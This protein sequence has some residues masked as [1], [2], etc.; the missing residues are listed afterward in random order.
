[1]TTNGGI[2]SSCYGWPSFSSAKVGSWLAEGLLASLF[3]PHCLLC[4]SATAGLDILCQGCL[5]SLPQ[6]TGAR[7]HRCQ[8]PLADPGADLCRTCG[9]QNR[10][11]DLARA[12]GPYEGSWGRLVCALKYGREKAVARFL[13]SRLAQYVEHE[14]AF[15]KVD[16]ITF[17]PMTRTELKTRGFNQ[18]LLLAHQFAKLVG[19]PVRRLMEKGR[20]TQPQV[21][22]SAKERRRNLH[23]AFRLLR[24]GEGSILLV[25][26]IF[27]TGSTVDECGRLLKNG[28]Y[29]A[30][31]VL[32]VAHS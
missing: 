4:Q 11:F 32:T 28:G 27:T 3:P 16:A 12:L 14:D 25:D 6:L 9:T 10:G 5:D 2:R 19:V 15:G 17:V 26:D 30:V 18:S 24:A 29:G 8:E 23:G 20:S 1:M 22:L 13:A 7:C 21:A 31:Y